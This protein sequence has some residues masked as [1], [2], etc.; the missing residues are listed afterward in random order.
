[1]FFNAKKYG[2]KICRHE[3]CQKQKT[4]TCRIIE[5]ESWNELSELNAPSFMNEDIKNWI[6]TEK[7]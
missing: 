5:T 7:H 2:H 6:M 3:I 4:T 1:M